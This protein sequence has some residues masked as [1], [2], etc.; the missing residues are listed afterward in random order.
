MLRIG[1]G[2]TPGTICGLLQPAAVIVTYA[3]THNEIQLAR[4]QAFIV[5]PSV[6][7]RLYAK[8]SDD[9]ECDHTELSLAQG[10]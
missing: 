8:A 9:K 10:D 5:V 1:A 3:S 7:T 2:S 6:L 4:I